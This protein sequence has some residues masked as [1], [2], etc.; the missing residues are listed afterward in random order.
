MTTI[1]SNYLKG[2]SVLFVSLLAACNSDDKN[3]TKNASD[4]K[5]VN[6]TISSLQTLS[7]NLVW[8]ENQC[9]SVYSKVINDAEIAE[10]S[11]LEL[12]T[13]LNHTDNLSLLLEQQIIPKLVQLT[14]ESTTLRA[15]CNAPD[16]DGTGVSIERPAMLR[17]MLSEWQGTINLLIR[18]INNT[19]NMNPKIKLAAL[20]HTNINEA[21]PEKSKFKDCSDSFCPEMTVIPSGSFLMGG[22]LQE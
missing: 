13:K 21:T 14:E 18:Q 15:R 6:G 19:P 22:N 16:Y 3:T 7:Q 2:F 8:Q 1:S 17:E 12:R 10:K 4:Q 20:T 11:A 9:D 5:L